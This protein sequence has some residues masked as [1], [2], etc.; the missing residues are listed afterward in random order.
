MFSDNKIQSKLGGGGGF[1]YG[2][3]ATCAN[4]IRGGWRRELNSR[5]IPHR[6]TPPPTRDKHIL[7]SLFSK[8]ARLA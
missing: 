3:A 4:S 7:L 6:V 1:N 2:P 8:Q 5:E